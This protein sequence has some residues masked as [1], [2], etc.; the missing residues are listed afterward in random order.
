M[1]PKCGMWIVIGTIS[2][3]TGNGEIT[4]QF[5]TFY[6]HPETNAGNKGDA[7]SVAKDILN[8]GNNPK[9]TLN[10]HLELVS[11]AALGID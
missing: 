2:T 4:R 8:P 7:L 3:K 6:L 10:I 9:I 1:E 11:V 5:P